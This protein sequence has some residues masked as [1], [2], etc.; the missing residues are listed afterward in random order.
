V[1][2]HPRARTS[3]VLTLLVG[4]LG[5]A[6]AAVAA[7][8]TWTRAPAAARGLPAVT[9]TGSD[10]APVVLPLS[11]VALAAWGTVLVL[12]VTGR[13]VVAVVGLAASVAAS[14]VALT[15]VGD[16]HG[17]SWPV[18]AGVAAALSAAGFGVVLARAQRWPEMSRRYD[19]PS[20][21][22]EQTDNDLWKALDEGRDPTV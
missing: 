21:Q 13:R 3:F 14:V 15:H 11:L 4:G 19:A 20:D 8:Q 10:V 5:A 9:A 7:H 18:V 6:V 1:A 16:T 22:P 17:T 12:R 2:E